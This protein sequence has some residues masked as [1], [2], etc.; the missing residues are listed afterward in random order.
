MGVVTTPTYDRRASASLFSRLRTAGGQADPFPIYEELLSRGAV[1]PAPW[2]GSLV[3]SFAV[4]DQVLRSRDWLEPDKRWRDIQGPGTRWNAPSS[5]EMSNTLAALNTPDHTRARRAAGTFDRSTVERISRTVSATTDR[6]LDTLSEQL[7]EGE[8]DFAALVG[9]ELPVATIGDWLGLP[10]ADWPRLR[11]LTHDQVFTQE[12]LPSASQLA[13]SDAATAELRAYFMDLVSDR[14]AHPGED[15]VSRWIQTWDAMEPDPDKADESVYFL[16]LFVLLAAL[17]TTSQ[18]L[19]TMTL[20]LVENPARRDLVAGRPD[21]VPGFVEETL[22]YDPPT[23]VISRVAAEDCFLD[24]MEIRKD[25]MVH[26]MVG[27]AHRDPARHSDPGRFDPLRQPG[28]LA[29]SGGIHYCLGAP[30]ARLEAQILLRQLTRRL[31]RL[32]LVRRPT[33]AP[34]VAFR[35][36]LNLDVALE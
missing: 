15:P 14:R 13:A 23:H 11:Q 36:L 9:E 27:A 32:T 18:L 28:H 30:L 24:G 16:V 31:P 33:M 29:F 2:G 20:L 35:R 12:L 6:L 7:R 5:R 22:R 19:T 8:A 3:S 1:S 21:L 10:A 4:C 25:E 17:E 34:R 26:L